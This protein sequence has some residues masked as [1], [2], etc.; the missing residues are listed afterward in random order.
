MRRLLALLLLVVALPAHGAPFS[1]ALAPRAFDFPRDHGAHPD[2]QTE[3]WYY[4]GHL[5]GDGRRYGYQF[6]IFRRALDPP[7]SLSP[8]FEGWRAAEI[9]PAHVALTEIDVRR[10]HHE[11]RLRRT[12]GGVA[13]ADTTDLR[14]WSGDW[15]VRRDGDAHVLSA[16]GPDFRFE[17]ELVPKKP[18]VLH[19]E[20]GLSRKGPRPGQASYYYS[21]T[22]MATAGTLW[23]DGRAHP[24]R[25]TSWMD[26]EF[27]SSDLDS[28]LAGWDWFSLQLDDGAELMLYR[29]RGATGPE[30]DRLSGT[31]VPPSGAPRALGPGD[32]LIVPLDTW[33]SPKTGATYPSLWR[34]EAPA[35]DL[36]LTVRPSLP[37]QELDTRGSTG[38]VYWEGSVAVS[39]LRGDRPVTGRGYAELTGYDGHVPMAAGRGGPPR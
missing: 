27:F 8:G 31:F 5:E 26:H 18:P 38:V 29:L 13:G 33:T 20:A 14:V 28:S 22:R 25:G 36:A 23:L 39:G 21:Y 37:D 6:V 10:F 35:L 11:E 4:T 17:L 30:T 12:I 32:F 3:W 1:Q 9:F 7:D 19:G 16:G 34:I 24:V 2:F 15:S